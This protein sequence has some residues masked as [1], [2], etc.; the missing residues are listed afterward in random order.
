V[1]AE[2]NKTV[3]SSKRTK[4]TAEEAI[5]RTEE[6]I[7]NGKGPSQEIKQERPKRAVITE[8]QAIKWTEEFASK[9]KE[10]FIAAIRKSKG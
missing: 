6:F 2:R 9:R 10:Q 4:V 1:N 8:E 7:E 5:R 3:E